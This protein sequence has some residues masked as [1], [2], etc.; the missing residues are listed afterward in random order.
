MRGLT[1]MKGALNL[2]S[3]TRLAQKQSP[4]R[5][6]VSKSSLTHIELLVRNY[7]WS[8]QIR[9]LRHLGFLIFSG[10]M[11]CPVYAQDLHAEQSA[12][13]MHIQG[14]PKDYDS[15]FR[16]VNIST[17]LRDYEAAIGALERLL[18]FNP[19]LA[20]AQKE[21]GFLYA[22]LG[23][24]APASE[25]LHAALDGDLDSA[26][27]AQISAQL[28]EIEKQ[29]QPNRLSVRI[30]A[31]LRSQSNANFFPA[32][33]LFQVGGLG[34]PSLSASRQGDVNA[35]QLVQASHDYDFE[36]QRGDQFETRVTG[37]ATEQF[38]LPQYSLTMFSASTGPRLFV[39]QNMMNSLSV[40]PYVIGV[41][42]TLGSVN[43]INTGGAGVGFRGVFDS[44]LT[45]EPGFEWR[46]LWVNRNYG[47][48]NVSPFGGTPYST[49]S[50]I[51]SGDALTG[52]LAGSYS[53]TESI[54]F[55]GRAAYSRANATYAPQSSDQVDIQS[56][57]KVAVAP[58]HPSINRRW[59]IA[60]YGRFTHLTFDAANPL[61]NPLVA[62]RDA[63]WSGGVMLDA[64]VTDLFG[65]SGNLEFW[66]NYSNIQNFSTQNMSV[67]FGPTMKF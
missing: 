20:R 4:L 43:Y 11:I 33:N 12:L 23:A 13:A 8:C 26:Q 19:K 59:T 1:E 6:K 46:S 62:R 41:I 38:R 34:V 15:T 48:N 35:F 55:E 60:P 5:C 51:A 56:M 2:I 63:A 7:R 50:T 57:L 65:F 64:P 3:G 42:S 14:N 47:L 54:V 52:Y 37:Y 53:L 66:R 10:W 29:N 21:L 58:P 31:G 17:E 16:F 61:I 9:F 30:H 44:G 32:N 27:K 28:P 40:R 24:W 36:N 39:P 18:M 25:H 45:L 22:R 67:T 49:A